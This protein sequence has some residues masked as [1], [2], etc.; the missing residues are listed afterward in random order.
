MLL[1][2]VIFLIFAH[3]IY[4]LRHLVSTFLSVSC[5]I[6]SASDFPNKQKIRF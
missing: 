5:K 2:R 3:D 1:V 6:L 4:F